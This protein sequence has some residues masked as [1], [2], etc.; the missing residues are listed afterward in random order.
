MNQHDTSI[1]P[2]LVASGDEQLTKDAHWVG[3]G[4]VDTDSIPGGYY[5]LVI[6][7]ISGNQSREAWREFRF[8]P[9]T[10]A[11]ASSIDEIGVGVQASYS[12]ANGPW[13]E[14]IAWT[15]SAD[16]LGSDPTRSFNVPWSYTIT[17]VSDDAVLET[18]QLTDAL[19]AAVDNPGYFSGTFTQP[20]PFQPGD[21]IV[22]ITSTSPAGTKSAAATV[23][24]PA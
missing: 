5:Q 13:M 8:R 9:R 23:T 19:F 16:Y 12:A 22:E 20:A 1:A 3:G 17:R 6:A 21:Y 24:V 7:V 11:P 2:I 15:A 18:S 14:N 10:V 4:T